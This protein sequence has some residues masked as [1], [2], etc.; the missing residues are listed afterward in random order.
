MQ[1][2]KNRWKYKLGMFFLGL[3]VIS[4]GLAFLVPLLNLS[5]SL[6]LTI[7]GSLLI[8]GPEVFMVLGVALAGKEALTKIK[9]SVKKAFGL[10][11]HD[12]PAGKT[13]Y[14]IGLGLILVGFL[15]QILLAY[16]PHIIE[17]EGVLE[18]RL[19]INLCTDFLI[20]GG[21]F[22]SGNQ[23][24]GKLKKLVTWEK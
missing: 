19:Y 21:V 20:I 6:T 15:V 8:G 2:E 22:T 17:M 4:P 11:I 16:L 10:P 1:K 12:Y 7:Q 24:I 23:F 13:Q 18:Y 3:M 14:E 5:Q 9:R